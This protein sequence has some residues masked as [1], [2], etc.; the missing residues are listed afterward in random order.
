MQ[1][2]WNLLVHTG[3]PSSNC[4][5]Q[6]L[7]FPRTELLTEIDSLLRF[8]PTQIANPI[9]WRNLFLLL[10]LSFKLVSGTHILSFFWVFCTKLLASQSMKETRT[11]WTNSFKQFNVEATSCKT[12]LVSITIWFL[13]YLL[14][15]R[16]Q[17]KAV[18]KEN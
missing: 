18:Q 9:D 11:S 10:K 13:N 7:N 14:I 17:F 3:S 4:D 1:K 15:F 8:L 16:N 12:F 2:F 5:L 6:N